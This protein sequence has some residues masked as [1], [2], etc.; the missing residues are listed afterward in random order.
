MSLSVDIHHHFDGF[1]LDV[2]FQT[3]GG[4]TALFGRSGAGKTTVINAL[5]GVF[6]PDRGRI[7]MSGRTLFD[8]PTRTD[9]PVHKRGLGYVFQDARLFPHMNVAQN[10]KYGA[11]FRKSRVSGDQVVEMLG[12][13]HLLDRRPAELSGGEK[14]RVAIGRALMSGPEMLLMDEPLAALD[15]ARKDDILPYLE[16]LRDEADLPILYVSH[17]IAEIGRLATSVVALEHGRVVRA[18]AAED[19]LSDPDAVATFGVQDA[20][21]MLRGRVV[22]HHDDG[23]TELAVG[24]G[25]LWLPRIMAPVD[26]TVRVRVEARDVM[27]SLQQPADISA[28]NVLPATVLSLRDGDGPGAM[29]QLQVGPDR[30]LARIT[31]RSAK[32]LN[33]RAGQT[34]FAVLKSVAVAKQDIGRG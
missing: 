18:G 32:A 25:Q 26:S 27:L 1:D 34:L 11:R 2:Q 23:L 28:L 16:R 20:G 3:E 9:V 17:S 14:Q 22:A 4:L 7:E 8:S 10:L 6:R 13:G 30:I 21:A 19:I 31:G 12:I 33:I 15:Q 24:G 5:A 29:V